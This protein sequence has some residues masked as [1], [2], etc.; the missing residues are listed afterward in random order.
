[1]AKQ[2]TFPSDMAG[3]PFS[4]EKW[5][6]QLRISI[7]KRAGIDIKKTKSK[8]AAAVKPFE[9]EIATVNAQEGNDGIFDDITNNVTGVAN[10]F[11]DKVRRGKFTK[12]VGGLLKETIHEVQARNYRHEQG[13]EL[14]SIYLPMPSLTHS[15]SAGWSENELGSMVG[16]FLNAND[17]GG[18][19]MSAAFDLAGAVMGGGGGGALG[20]LIGEGG[21][22][23]ILGA[24]GSSEFQAGIESGFGIKSN[25]YKEATFDGI[26]FRDYTFQF[27]LNPRNDK[28]AGDVRE[29]IKLMRTNSKPEVHGSLFK[30]PNEFRLEFLTLKGDEL[31]TNPFIPQIKYCVCTNVT[32]NYAPNGWQS[33]DDGSP[34]VT[35]LG[36]SFKETELVVAQDVDGRKRE[37]KMSRFD[38]HGKGESDSIN[39]VAGDEIPL[40]ER[41]LF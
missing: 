24:L 4:S 39:I 1:M 13:T 3:A 16:G 33:H 40:S 19:A 9:E 26:G 34:V 17:V 31:I 23:A 30:Y 36:L 22:G 5:N 14:A 41:G 10:V 12:S 21:A 15:D 2:I 20:S 18:S 8:A 11:K 35:Q 38:R 28:E 37:E 32:T 7:Y 29:I 25:P 27:D 6:D